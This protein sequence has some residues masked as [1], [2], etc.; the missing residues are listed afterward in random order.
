M[1]AHRRAL[2]AASA[3]SV[4]TGQKV[5][6]LYDFAAGEHLR[7]AAE[8]RGKQVQGADGDRSSAFGG[9]LPDIYDAA[10][11][12]FVSLEVEGDKAR[13]YDHGSAGHYEARVTDRLIQLYDHA[14]QAWFSFEPQIA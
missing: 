1:Q 12:A 2:V 4:I 14:Q 9:N 5:A 13:G 8:C 7:V 6:G 10:D 3:Y 11:K